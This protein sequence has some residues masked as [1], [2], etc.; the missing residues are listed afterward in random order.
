MDK[1]KKH[2]YV[3]QF[4]LKGFLNPK[5][6]KKMI[7]VYDKNRNKKFKSKVSNIAFQKNFNTIDSLGEKRYSL[8][9]QLA[10]IE[11]DIAP[12]IKQ[13]IITNQKPSEDGYVKLFNYI[14]L[15]Y[16][17]NP[18]MR[19]FMKNKEEREVDF[20]LKNVVSSKEICESQLIKVGHDI[21]EV[22]FE[23]IK[24]FV[25]EK[26][27][28]IDEGRERR[29]EEELRVFDSILPSIF[30]R[31]WYF[32]VSSSEIGEFITSDSPVSLVSS[33]GDLDYYGLGTARTELIFPISN[34]I[35]MVGTFE[36]YTDEIFIQ[37][38]KITIDRI[39]KITYK[40]SNN[41]VYSLRDIDF[42]KYELDNKN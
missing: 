26:R 10:I 11:S 27:Y 36:L 5:D 15:L 35:C 16:L 30:R 39:N 9:K 19:Q 29:I 1:P 42:G 7:F 2:H 28:I 24:S 38:D 34:Y 25:L 33:D 40:E 31:I 32:Y 21:N 18:K 8:E 37:A 22:S 20:L 3:S 6:N 23:D 41:Q 13:I 12:I 4:Y 14:G 17:R